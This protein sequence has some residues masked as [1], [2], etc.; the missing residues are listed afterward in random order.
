MENGKEWEKKIRVCVCSPGME[1]FICGTLYP[2]LVVGKQQHVMVPR[3][4]ISVPT[5][6]TRIDWPRAVVSIN[7]LSDWSLES[8]HSRVK[9]PLQ[10]TPFWKRHA[11]NKINH[12]PS[13]VCVSYAHFRRINNAICNKPFEHHMYAWYQSRPLFTIIN[14]H[15][16][17]PG[18]PRFFPTSMQKQSTIHCDRLKTLSEF[19][20]RTL[21][22][23]SS[24]PWCRSTILDRAI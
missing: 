22:V 2:T 12:V 19:G 7:N 8:K 23:L 24:H 9:N 1:R 10:R 16:V 5:I 18:I 17:P 14:Q 21:A 11:K 13:I 6:T 20:C 15:P 4:P 3:Y